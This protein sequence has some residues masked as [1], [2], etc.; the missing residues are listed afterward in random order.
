MAD[1]MD[2]YEVCSLI[3]DPNERHQCYSVFGLD[4][5]K[6]ANYYDT[7]V[8]L[9]QQL[10]SDFDN[11]STVSGRWPHLWQ[12]QHPTMPSPFSTKGGSSAITG[13]NPPPPAAAAALAV[14][15]LAMASKHLAWF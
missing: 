9:E 12:Q 13:S 15:M 11:P 7:V 10:S 5:Q 4:A 2:A 3:P 6:M 1:I 14:A 8:R